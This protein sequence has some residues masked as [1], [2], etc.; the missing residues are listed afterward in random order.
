MKLN[1]NKLVFALKNS[2]VPS[3]FQHRTWSTDYNNKTV[4]Y[5]NHLL[6]EKILETK[7]IKGNAI[8]KDAF[9]NL[10]R[11]FITYEECLILFKRINMK[12]KCINF[13]EFDIFLECLDITDYDNI[14]GSLE[15]EQG[16]PVTP[17]IEPE[18]DPEPEPE[19]EKGDPV[20]LDIEPEQG[21]SVVPDIEPEKEPKQKDKNNIF[22]NIKNFFKYF[23]DLF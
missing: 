22:T 5:W 8:D 15:P 17:D 6:W 13:K 4:C 12:S 14:I 21:H 19:P 23:I 16:D 1:E 18:P 3:L 9:Y 10:C 2:K 20:T 11:F 7:Y